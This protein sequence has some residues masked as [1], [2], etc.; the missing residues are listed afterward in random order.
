MPDNS[1]PADYFDKMYLANEDPWDFETSDYERKKY[2]ATVN[3]L[4]KSEY[5]N[6]FEIGCSIGV[7]T[8][9]LATRCEKLLSVD[10]SEVPLTKARERLKNSPHVTIS[11]MQVPAVFPKDKFDLL[12]ISEVGYYWSW[13]DLEK[14]QK[15]IAASMLPGGHLI[16]VHWT[17][18]VEDYPLRGDEVHESFHDFGQQQNWKYLTGK[19]EEKYRL[20]LWE[21]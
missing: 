14:A 4:P 3:A 13:Q 17:P 2:L 5:K 6:G 1:L 8:H 10:A 19:R 11:R 15:A 16:L 12:V 7:L 21:I 18:F 9:L 20:D